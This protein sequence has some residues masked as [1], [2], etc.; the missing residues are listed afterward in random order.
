M[1]K[2]PKKDT[3]RFASMAPRS[4]TL[5]SSLQR[6]VHALFLCFGLNDNCQRELVE[7]SELTE[8]VSDSM[9]KVYEFLSESQ[10]DSLIEFSTKDL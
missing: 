8:W 9:T 5:V 2:V 3:A 10:P 6:Q 1:T 7:S 4:L